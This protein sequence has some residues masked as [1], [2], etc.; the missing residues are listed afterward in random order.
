MNKQT[1]SVHQPSAPVYGFNVPPPPSYAQAVGGVA[2]SS[3]YVPPYASNGIYV[4]IVTHLL[5]NIKFML[6]NL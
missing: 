1:N 3:P 4:C 5:Y 6:L 2:P